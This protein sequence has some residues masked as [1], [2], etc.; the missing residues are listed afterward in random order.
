MLHTSF[1]SN[2]P[3]AWTY[4][5]LYDRNNTIIAYSEG[6]GFQLSDMPA[7]NIMANLNTGTNYKLNLHILAGGT[8]HAIRHPDVG[9]Q[10]VTLI[11]AV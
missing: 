8:H 10:L 4:M 6:V 3:D 1:R 11:T 2:G 7:F 9:Y 5:I